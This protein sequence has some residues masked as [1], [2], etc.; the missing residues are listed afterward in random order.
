VKRDLRAAVKSKGFTP[1]ASDAAALVLLLEDEEVGK[2]AERALERIGARA[3]DALLK[4]KPTA[5][6]TRAL[7][8]FADDPR[9]QDAM[10]AA[11][12]SDDAKTRRNAVIALGKV[13]AAEEPLLAYW[14]KE[15]RV[16]HRRSV[17]A[18]LGKI[19]GPRSLALLRQVKSEDA[20]LSRIVERAVLMLERTALREEEGG[21]IDVRRAP[22]KPARVLLRCR[23]GLEP[24]LVEETRGEV[25]R[26][27]RVIV[28]L[29]RP[30]E[31]L[32]AARTFVDLAFPL[33]QQWIRDREDEVAA[34]VRALASEEAWEIFRAFTAGPPRYRVSFAKGGHRRAD[35]FRVAR[36]VARRRPE[37]VNDPTSSVWEATVVTTNR[38]VDVELAPR[39]LEDPRFTY[40]KGDVPAA[41][42]PTLAAALV[43]VAE[44]REE[45]VVWDPF[46][47]S[48]TE[49]VEARKAKV[50]IGTDVDPRALE[51]AEGNLAAAGV[52]AELTIGDARAHEPGPVTLILTNPPMGRRVVRDSTIGALL[53]DF[54]G[55]AAEVLLPGGRLVWLSPFG[56]R[57][58]DRAH[59]AG[60]H[61][62]LRRTVDMGGFPAELQKLVKR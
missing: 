23:S 6:T 21:S 12:D 7:S 37:L 48:G 56:E 2:D 10:I 54:V 30:L 39:A 57:T 60:L 20:E 61:V 47:G 42:H 50:L 15:T 1:K 59:R 25:L 55:H 31:S 35:V 13:K 51:I 41:S 22:D 34:A 9:A 46:V 32:F 3:L 19:G 44:V 17:A 16:D 49:L 14:H 40:R 43:H 4:A 53:D 36:E 5:R 29:D 27:G 26:P 52:N 38:F 11:L 33:P 62:E 45:D 8:R 24:I 28:T 18:S 58:V